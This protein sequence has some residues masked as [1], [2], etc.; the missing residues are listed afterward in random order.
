[1][2]N[3]PKTIIPTNYEAYMDGYMAG[4]KFCQK[5]DI[6][7]FMPQ[8]NS[9]NPDNKPYTG[10]E[11][12][13]QS[14]PMEEKDVICPPQKSDTGKDSKEWE[15]TEIRHREMD[16]K[17][18]ILTTPEK[19]K[20]ALDADLGHNW[21]IYS[22]RSNGQIFSVGETVLW[23]D[24]P[25]VI[26]GFKI[27]KGN[28]S[29]KSGIM[30]YN[31]KGNDFNIFFA[32]KQPQPIPEKTVTDNTDVLFTTEDGVD[33]ANVNDTVWKVGKTD[34]SIE[35]SNACH[36]KN[37]TTYIQ[38]GFL[39]FSTEKA[40]KNHIK[41]NAKLLSFNDVW[42]LS[43][44]KSTDKAYVVIKKDDLTKAVNQKLKTHTP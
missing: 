39:V 31:K 19:I 5:Y 37:N 2:S 12:I 43:D 27:D 42:N 32:T 17:D 9:L 11:F 29:V 13:R 38:Q 4:V 30:F 28:N 33:I 35:Q 1:M 36:V 21:Y 25:L 15:V 41:C 10:K 6:P 40:A 44:N 24:K 20:N 22:V 8:V 18:W 23:G 34:F 3:T 7:E 14:K 26:N 16:G